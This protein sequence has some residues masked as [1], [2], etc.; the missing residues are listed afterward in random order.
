MNKTKKINVI[1]AAVMQSQNDQMRAAAVC[2]MQ[3]EHYS[4]RS[5][6][7]LL[8]TL[9]SRSALRWSSSNPLSMAVLGLSRT[10]AA[11]EDSTL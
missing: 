8:S 4:A 11:D 1:P 5:V 6:N 3:F 2:N 7:V 10:T 9:G